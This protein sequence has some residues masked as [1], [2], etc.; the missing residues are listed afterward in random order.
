M[1]GCTN[2]WHTTNWTPGNYKEVKEEGSK[3]LNS[4]LFPENSI[5]LTLGYTSV[6]TVLSAPSLLHS[7][8][9]LRLMWLTSPASID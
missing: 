9:H 6:F 4:V 8:D 1:R 2:A 5:I 7:P 3:Q